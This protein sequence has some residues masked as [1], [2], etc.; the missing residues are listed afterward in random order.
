MSTLKNLPVRI[1]NELANYQLPRFTDDIKFSI[2]EV[3]DLRIVLN[4][5]KV[6]LF[7]YN[8]E[9]VWNENSKINEVVRGIDINTKLY[10][11][12]CKKM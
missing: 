7:I 5:K 9:Q 10:F 8:N 11:T 2:D 6:S 1:I 12:I 4:T 3:S